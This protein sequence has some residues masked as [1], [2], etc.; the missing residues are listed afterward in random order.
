[1]FSGSRLTSLFGRNIATVA[2][3]AYDASFNS[4][5]HEACGFRFATLILERLLTPVGKS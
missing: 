5:F 4:I 3:A 1:M 2:S